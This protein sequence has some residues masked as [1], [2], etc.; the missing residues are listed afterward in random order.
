MEDKKVK[1]T[2]SICGA[3]TFSPFGPGR[4]ISPTGPISP[5][6]Q[7]GANKKHIYMHKLQIKNMAQTRGFHSTNSQTMSSCQF[8][9]HSLDA[10]INFIVLLPDF[11]QGYTHHE[12]MDEY[13]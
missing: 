5:C 2:A 8:T 13:K 11:P 4:P 10:S 7:R 9:W 12:T 1:V 6:R 3:F